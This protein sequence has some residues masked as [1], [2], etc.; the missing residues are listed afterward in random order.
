MAA[1][2]PLSLLPGRLNN[3]GTWGGAP[4]D[5]RVVW[6][7]LASPLPASILTAPLPSASRKD[8]GREVGR[9]GGQTPSTLGVHTQLGAVCIHPLLLP[10]R[11]LRTSGSCTLAPAR[12]P[13]RADAGKRRWGVARR[14]PRRSME[15]GGR[16][17]APRAWPPRGPRPS[18]SEPLG[19]G[20]RRGRG[21]H[22]CGLLPPRFPDTPAASGSCRILRSPCRVWCSGAGAGRLFAR[23]CARKAVG[24]RLRRSERP[25][26]RPPGP[27]AWKGKCGGGGGGV[28]PPLSTPLQPAPTPGCLARSRRRRTGRSRFLSEVRSSGR[29]PRGGCRGGGTPARRRRQR[30]RRAGAGPGPRRVA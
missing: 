24:L 18:G 30:Q 7:G 3:E 12:G 23:R 19:A 2:S 9:G 10:A 26:G 21:A 6:P 11:L 14:G 16:G 17:P 1:P 8:G 20:Q 28:G 27:R 4:Q 25:G 13:H 29:P 5:L 22:S 15:A